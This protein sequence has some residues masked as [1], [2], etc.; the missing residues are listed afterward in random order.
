[1]TLSKCCTMRFVCN[2]I[3]KTSIPIFSGHSN[4][5][6]Y[7][8]YVVFSTSLHIYST[9]ITK[10]FHV[11]F[12]VNTATS[13]MF[14]F[15]HGIFYSDSLAVS[16]EIM[17]DCTFIAHTQVVPLIIQTM[18]NNSQNSMPLPLEITFQTLKKKV[19]EDSL[20]RNAAKRNR[21]LQSE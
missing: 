11:L 2:D 4:R 12:K 14:F 7:C 15:S 10:S 21:I 18:Q 16:A 17:T 6:C 1:M 13:I 5:Q 9:G 19:Q 20:N 8:G 3:A